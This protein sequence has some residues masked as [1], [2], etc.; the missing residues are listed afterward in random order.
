MEEN[1]TPIY[2]NKSLNYGLPANV[3]G[4]LSPQQ[5]DF[6]DYYASKAMTDIAAGRR[7]NNVTPETVLKVY[8]DALSD[9]SIDSYYKQQLELGTR[10]LQMSLD[11]LNA[12]DT[13][14]REKAT[15]AFEEQRMADDEAAAAAGNAYSS[16]RNRTDENRRLDEVGVT[17]LRDR[18]ARQKAF[19]YGNA[20]EKNYGSSN[21]PNI[22]VGGQGYSRFGN[23]VGANENNKAMS[24]I[25]RAQDRLAGAMY[26]GATGGTALPMDAAVPMVPTAKPTPAVPS[27]P[28]NTIIGG[29][30]YTPGGG[31]VNPYGIK[32]NV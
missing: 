1:T 19:E 20:F 9:P 21:T 17:E 10:E 3:Y 30:E 11:Y 15:R 12:A 26:S 28:G 16:Y 24:Q 27:A 22:S 31:L 5:R 29:K 13:A 6:L 32:K 8:Q 18:N 2:W 25:S 7:V 14:E 23:V 4:Q